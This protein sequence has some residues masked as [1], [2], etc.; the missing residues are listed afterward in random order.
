MGVT[1]CGLTIY[2]GKE[3]RNVTANEQGDSKRRS[4]WRGR[5]RIRF[6]VKARRF[7]HG[8]TEIVQVAVLNWNGAREGF[9]PIESHGILAWFGVPPFQVGQGGTNYG[10]LFSFQ[11]CPRHKELWRA[12]KAIPQHEPLIFR[13]LI[14]SQIGSRR[15]DFAF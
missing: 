6:A 12:G 14:P 10:N 11:P 1:T 3:T 8:F 5:K 2:L 15:L 13:Q 4:L 9:A 7:A